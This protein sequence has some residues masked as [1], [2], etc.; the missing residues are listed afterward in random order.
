MLEMNYQKAVRLFCSTIMRSN[1]VMAALILSM[2]ASTAVSAPPSG[3]STSFDIRA[4]SLNV[5]APV[6]AIPADYPTQQLCTP[7]VSGTGL[8]NYLD[9]NWRRTK[10]S[11][12]FKYQVPNADFYTLQETQQSEN[13]LL[14]AIFD[15][16]KYWYATAYHDISYW[17]NYFNSSVTGEP[18][19]QS[20]VA[21]AVSKQ[22][23]SACN[24]NDVSL[25]TGNH[26]LVGVCTHTNGK[27]VRIVSVHFDSDQ[28]GRRGKETNAL[29]DYLN[30]MGGG[31]YID[32]IAGDF[33]ADT[34]SGVLKSRMIDQEGFVDVL[35]ATGLGGKPT[36]PWGTGYYGNQLYSAIDHVVARGANV[37][38]KSSDIHDADLYVTYPATTQ[39]NEVPR[40]CST[41]DYLGTDHFAVEGTIRVQ[42]P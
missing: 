20:G 26:A 21:M 32:I 29:M 28:G 25:T 17:S 7:Y 2:F 11:N 18:N 19:Q 39:S 15:S 13:P 35:T 42:L 22:K 40:Q 8:T 4:V 24:F 41:F 23:Y 3:G 37:S 27:K 12:F 30:A 16:R 33:N 31:P 1:R 10:V 14:A 9:K 5:L 38:P 36:H 34:D 6:W